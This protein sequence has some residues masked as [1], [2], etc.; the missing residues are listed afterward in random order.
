MSPPSS[1]FE[2]WLNSISNAQWLLDIFILY[3]FLTLF[4][5]VYKFFFPTVTPRCAACGHEAPGEL[6]ACA[7]C[8]TSV[9]C[10]DKGCLQSNEP[11]HRAVCAALRS[12]HPDLAAPLT[13]LAREESRASAA[14]FLLKH[15][16]ERDPNVLA[17]VRNGAP[18]NI[19]AAL[20]SAESLHSRLACTFLV[21]DASVHADACR[22]F[23]ERGAPEAVVKHMAAFSEATMQHAGCHCLA[24]LTVGRT[25][26]FPGA[27]DAAL[28][29]MD[30]HP[31]DVRVAVW[32]CALLGLG[33][34]PGTVHQVWQALV[35]ALGSHEGSA[36]V[37]EPACGAM[38]TL[39]AQDLDVFLVD[40][41]A[42]KL[43]VVLQVHASNAE[44]AKMA[45]NAVAHLA[46]YHVHRLTGTDL[47]DALRGVR[48]AA[49]LQSKAALQ[50]FSTL[51]KKHARAKP[52]R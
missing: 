26:P 23:V 44:V 25:Q 16:Q 43:L 21:S 48:H 36:K 3:S 39:D 47:P 45:C 15:I 50:H 1:V 17:L 27:I 11:L 41:V 24:L 29:A 20:Q 14:M 51:G 9:F 18:G 6:V 19:A 35:R 42:A 32:A 31:T 49:P 22:E 34:E 37:A 52:K 5:Q 28:A 33:S 40:A 7:A 8:K 2:D 12:E 4:T 10:K 46:S 30:S 38:V 13:D